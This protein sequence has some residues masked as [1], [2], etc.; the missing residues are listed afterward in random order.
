[1]MALPNATIYGVAQDAE[2]FIWL[3]STNSGLCC[4]MT[5]ISLLSF[6]C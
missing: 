3:S 5:V 4:A 2:G 6:R 1:M